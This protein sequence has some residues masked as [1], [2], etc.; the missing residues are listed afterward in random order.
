MEVEKEGQYVWQ[1][2]IAVSHQCQREMRTCTTSLTAKAGWCPARDGPPDSRH[3]PSHSSATLREHTGWR[4]GNCFD[5]SLYSS[6]WTDRIEVHVKCSRNALSELL[7]PVVSPA[8]GYYFWWPPNI[9]DTTEANAPLA[10][11][12][13]AIEIT[14][15]GSWFHV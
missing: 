4:A 6:L 9:G 11:L 12:M 8:A 7:Y 13:L 3:M 15:N 2:D 14:Q 1:M 10:W 5:W